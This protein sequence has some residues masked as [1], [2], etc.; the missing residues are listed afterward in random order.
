MNTPAALDFNTINVRDVQDGYW[1]ESFDVNANG[2]SD[3]IAYGLNTGDIKWF[4][5]PGASKVADGSAWKEH[6]IPKLRQPVG[7]AHGQ[8]AATEPGVCPFEDLVFTSEYGETMD[9]IN[10][11]G[12]LIYWFE[13]PR[14]RGDAWWIKRYI[15]RAAGMHRLAVEYFTQTEHLEVLALPV[16]GKAHDTHSVVTVKLF[17]QPANVMDA[18]E[19]NETVIDSTSFHVIHD[20]AVV[21]QRVGRGDMRDSALLASQEGITLLAYGAAGWRTE[22]LFDGVPKTSEGGYWGCQNVAV[23]RIG[24]DPFGY[25]ARSGPF[26]GNVMYILT[27]EYGEF[28]TLEDCTWKPRTLAVFGNNGAPARNAEGAIHHIAAADMDNDGE[29]ECLV[30]LRDEGVRYFKISDLDAGTVEWRRA[31]QASAARVAVADFSGDGRLDFATIAYGVQGYYVANKLT[32]N[33]HLNNST[34]SVPAEVIRRTLR[35][36][37]EVQVCVPRL[38]ASSTGLGTALVG[39]A[40]FDF[41]PSSTFPPR[42]ATRARRASCPRA[43]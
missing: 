2:K 17:Q 24:D 26:H 6:H 36:G 18:P 41:F 28:G 27:K 42:R 21:K 39:I 43:S 12:G 9:E 20:V 33:L 19:W 3:L 8:I 23:G 25:I 30:A 7:M 11:D 29:D 38:R 32:L 22:R 35:N 1:I 31:S 15:G 4:E 10:E 14:G 16:V 34:A 13:N 37:S 5:N 40:G